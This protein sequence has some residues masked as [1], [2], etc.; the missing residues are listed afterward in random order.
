MF[1]MRTKAR[2]RT[3]L[4]RNFN[5]SSRA[6]LTVVYN[7]RN[8]SRFVGWSRS[9][10]YFTYQHFQA[11]GIALESR[12]L[13][14]ISKVYELTKDVSLLSYSMDAVLETGF[15]LSYRDHVLKFLYPLFPHPSTGKGAQHAHT[16]TR[17]LVTLDDTPLVVSLLVSLIPADTL[18]A[19]QFAFDFVAA[20][21][22]DFLESVRNELPPGS[23]VSIFNHGSAVSC[24]DFFFAGGHPTR[25]HQAQEHLDGARFCQA[26]PPISQAE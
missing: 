11:I 13:D 25:I 2:T 23:D 22:Q 4:T 12:R 21:S 19:Y 17:L 9:T 18:L 20:A 10:I 14:I 3:R 5:S 26:L 24:V 7:K 8:T 6:S 1:E 15:S 16:L